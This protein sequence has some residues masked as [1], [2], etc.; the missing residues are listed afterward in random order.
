MYGVNRPHHAKMSISNVKVIDNAKS[1]VGSE[2]FGNLA[3][4]TSRQQALQT[5]LKENQA[6]KNYFDNAQEFLTG[7]SSVLKDKQGNVAAKFNG[8]QLNIVNENVFKD[9]FGTAD[10][11]VIG[12][13]RSLMAP[14][15][16]IRA[17]KAGASGAKLTKLQSAEDFFSGKTNVLDFGQG[18][19]ASRGQLGK[20]DIKEGKGGELSSLGI[21]LSQDILKQK[22]VAPTTKKFTALESNLKA[23]EATQKALIAELKTAQKERIKENAAASA[24]QVDALVAARQMS[25]RDAVKQKS[26]IAKVVAAETAKINAVDESN[27]AIPDI[28]EI[29][30]DLKSEAQRILEGTRGIITATKKNAAR[31]KLRQVVRSRKPAVSP[32]GAVLKV[33]ATVPRPRDTKRANQDINTNAGQLRNPFVAE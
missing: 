13:T 10:S 1:S 2:T 17:Q 12:A 15:S 24:K 21:S 11:D 30:T 19:V 23:K 3:D 20:I 22:A 14:I 18:A 25:R 29:D 33:G 7:K 5:K 28:E 4:L 31:Q 32:V 26:E 27:I 9:V 16:Q 8:N 6:V